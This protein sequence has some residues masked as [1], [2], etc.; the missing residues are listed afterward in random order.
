M[1]NNEPS[2]QDTEAAF[3]TIVQY[4]SQDS[5]RTLE[6]LRTEAVR[7]ALIET[8]G[9]QKEAGELLNISPRVVNFYVQSHGL[10]EMYEEKKGRNLTLLPQY[11][12][13]GAET[14]PEPTPPPGQLEI[15]G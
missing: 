8:N 2:Q 9:N 1:S 11:R 3:R 5:A 14:F 15:N 12:R 4:M 6:W 10:S 7:T 13:T